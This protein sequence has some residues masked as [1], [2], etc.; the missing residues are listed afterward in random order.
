M[1]LGQIQPH[2]CVCV[3]VC[4]RVCACVQSGANNVYKYKIYK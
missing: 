3:C 2:I 1:A 4:A